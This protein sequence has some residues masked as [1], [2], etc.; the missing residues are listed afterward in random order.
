MGLGELVVKL[1]ILG[2]VVLFAK[3]A[4]TTISETTD[5]SPRTLPAQSTQSPAPLMTLSRWAGRAAT[6]AAGCA[7]AGLVWMGTSGATDDKPEAT[8]VAQADTWVVTDI[9]DGDTINVMRDG[10][11]EEVRLVS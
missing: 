9:V 1:V 11:S 6:F 10:V 4:I 2:L 8:P 3:A 7:A 5:D